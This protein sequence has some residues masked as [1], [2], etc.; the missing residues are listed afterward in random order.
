MS[1][2]NGVKLL[3]CKRFIKSRHVVH[4]RGL[5]IIQAIGAAFFPQNALRGIMGFLFA[6]EGMLEEN[7]DNE[8]LPPLCHIQ[9]GHLLRSTPLGFLE[10][11]DE[12]SPALRKALSIY[13]ST[14]TSQK[15]A[16]I[17]LAIWSDTIHSPLNTVSCRLRLKCD[18]TRAGPRFRLSAKRTSPFNPLNAELNPIYHLLA[19]LG[20]RLIFHVS[21][22]RVKSAG[23]SVQ[24]T[25]GSQGVR[26]S[27][28]NAGY[29]IFRGSVKSTGYPLHSPVSP[30]LPLPCATVCHHI[31]TGL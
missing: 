30:S 26:I 28:S 16:V 7:T 1:I 31:S 23:V 12:D 17:C 13:Q 19:L 10:P 4:N 29:I 24:S 6:W 5:A 3:T 8:K 22:I 9:L 2:T 18:G 20:A 14:S 15:T 27:G 11:E 25:T 21:R